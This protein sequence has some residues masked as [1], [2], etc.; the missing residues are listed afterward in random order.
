[1]IA[2]LLAAKR[3]VGATQAKEDESK[4]YISAVVSESKPMRYWHVT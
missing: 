4:I 1:M 2:G 3:L